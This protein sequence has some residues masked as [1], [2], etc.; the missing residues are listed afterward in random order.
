MG[1]H[2]YSTTLL[3]FNTQQHA[4]FSHSVRDQTKY[5]CLTSTETH[6]FD[7]S[8]AAHI[9]DIIHCNSERENIE[10]AELSPCLNGVALKILMT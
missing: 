9:E 2:Y 4:T 10:I 5:L 3:K 6:I 8:T 1:N 7:L